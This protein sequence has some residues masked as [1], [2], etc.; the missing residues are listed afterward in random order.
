MQPL[1]VQLSRSSHIDNRCSFRWKVNFG[2]LIGSF[3]FISS[4]SI[5][6][7]SGVICGNIEEDVSELRSELFRNNLY[8]AFQ[9]LNDV[10]FRHKLLMCFVKDMSFLETVSV[11][12]SERRGKVRLS[13]GKVGEVRD[14]I[15][16]AAADKNLEMFLFEVPMS[17]SLCYVPVLN[18]PN[19]GC[20]MKGV[21]CFIMQMETFEGGNGNGNVNESFVNGDDD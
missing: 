5:T 8:V 2:N 19:S 7:G 17:V 12:D 3:L 15:R 6:D 18:L 11:V 13:G 1:S 4:N 20:E 21:T 14:W 16:L 10:I 9:C